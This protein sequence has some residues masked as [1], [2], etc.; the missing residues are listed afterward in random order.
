MLRKIL[1]KLYFYGDILVHAISG[2]LGRFIGRLLA[3]G[4]QKNIGKDSNQLY[5]CASSMH[6]IQCMSQVGDPTAQS[7]FFYGN[8]SNLSK[9][10]D[11][12]DIHGMPISGFALA[13][14]ILTSILTRKSL[15]VWLPHL[16][17]QILSNFCYSLLREI[18][19]NGFLCFFDDGTSSFTE[20][21]II[22]RKGYLPTGFSVSSWN[23][24]FLGQEGFPQGI[25]KISSFEKALQ[26]LLDHPSIG[27]VRFVNSICDQSFNTA[28]SVNALKSMHSERMIIA[29][30]SKH[31]DNESILSQLSLTSAKNVVY[32]PHY[33]MGKNHLELNK[34]TK[35]WHCGFLEY[36]L[37]ELCRSKSTVIY[38]G[39]TSTVLILI[40]LLVRCPQIV[41]VKF[42]FQPIKTVSDNY[43]ELEKADYIKA[44]NF[45][46]SS[47]WTR[48]KGIQFANF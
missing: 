34:I 37:Y 36:S 47:D 11:K 44:L 23:Y 33:R 9:E 3:I 5:I 31:L 21:N 30:A 39:I 16:S 6:I 41:D 7:H 14:F 42:I 8:H 40:E 26:I 12:V 22:N 2:F 29:L 24:M 38:H 46:R 18:Q 15:K 48:K 19:I 17:L 45:Y 35:L 28:C 27:G 13:K 25:Q 4:V 20:N 43:I 1:Q 32:A 10:F